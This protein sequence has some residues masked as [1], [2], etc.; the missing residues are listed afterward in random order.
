M[1]AYLSH[2]TPL[3]SYELTKKDHRWQKDVEQIR[4]HVKA[5]AEQW[6]AEE[7]ADPELKQ[8]RQDN[9]VR[10]LKMR[11]SWP[12]TP[13]HELMR[14]RIRLYCGHIHETS[15]H[16]TIESPVLHGSS[17]TECTECGRN[18]AEIVAYEP[19]GLKSG[20]PVPQPGPLATPPKPTRKQLESQLAELKAEVAALKA[21]RH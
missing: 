15:R 7:S 9:V 14:W 10:V 13:D 20:Q 19:V 21:A 18:P 11:A 3:E 16:S 8:D 17:S 5:Q 4:K 2:G 1:T 6:K 12:K